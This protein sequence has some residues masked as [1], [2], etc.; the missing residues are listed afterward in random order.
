MPAHVKLGV[1]GENVSVPPLA[2]FPSPTDPEGTHQTWETPALLGW[3]SP[4]PSESP[5][6]IA[7]HPASAC[8]VI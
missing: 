1:T 3:Q 2:A 6:V 5:L 7:H 8:L 4:S